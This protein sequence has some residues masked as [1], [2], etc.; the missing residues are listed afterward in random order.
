MLVGNTFF[1][2]IVYADDVELLV[3]CVGGLESMLNVCNNFAEE[4]GLHF[5]VIKTVCI[6]YHSKCH[7]QGTVKQFSVSLGSTKLKWFDYIKHL[8]HKL[9]CCL[10][11]THCIKYLRGQ[12]IRVVNQIQTEDVCLRKLSFPQWP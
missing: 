2:C 7:L 3:L 12:F 6:K 5:N 4:N 1:G 8:S 9:N 11:S 10:K